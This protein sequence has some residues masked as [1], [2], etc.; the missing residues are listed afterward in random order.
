MSLAELQTQLDDAN[1]KL[2]WYTVP[3]NA[4]TSP[5]S[6]D[7]VQQEI[8][9]LEKEIKKMVEVVEPERK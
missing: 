3:V 1:D 7:L 6:I 2:F 5:T 4:D 9:E 8:I